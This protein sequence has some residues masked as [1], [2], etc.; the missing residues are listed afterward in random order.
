VYRFRKG[1]KLKIKAPWIPRTLKVVA[2]NSSLSSV[3]PNLQ[4]VLSSRPWIFITTA[5]RS[6][7]WKLFVEEAASGLTILNII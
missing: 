3:N 4:S 5:V 7:N 1:V 2:D 6:Q